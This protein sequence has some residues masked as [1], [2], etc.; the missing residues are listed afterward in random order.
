MFGSI[1]GKT[2][3]TDYGSA[4]RWY[5]KELWFGLVWFGLF[6]FIREEACSH[7]YML[8]DALAKFPAILLGEPREAD[9][10]TEASGWNCYEQLRHS[11]VQA[12]EDNFV[13]A[14][15]T[16]TENEFLI[17]VRI[18]VPC[19]RSLWIFKLFS[20]STI[21]KYDTSTDITRRVFVHSYG[22]NHRKK[23]YTS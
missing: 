2:F 3:V 17:L 10:I 21:I 7:G 20:Q 11:A 5:L 22:A 13:S 23:N 15:L 18:S 1:F 14:S 4:H 12:M 6:C 9:T 19:L 8:S 16:S